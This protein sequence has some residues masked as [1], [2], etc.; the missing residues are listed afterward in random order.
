M[1]NQR[2]SGNPWPACRAIHA[3]VLHGLPTTRTLASLDATA[4]KSFPCWTNIFPL[5]PNSSDRSMPGFL[6]I[7]PTQRVQSAPSN[8]RLGSVVAIISSTSGHAPSRNS[9]TTPCNA[10]SAAGTS[11]NWRRTFWLGPKSP[12]EA[13]RNTSAYPI[14][15]AAPVTAT[16]ITSLMVFS[17]PPSHEPSAWHRLESEYWSDRVEI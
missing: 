8:A 3:F 2:S 5:S 6:G 7:L 13:I 9:M 11:N 15:P 4:A 17:K 16:R 14:C 10:F 1:A 12:P